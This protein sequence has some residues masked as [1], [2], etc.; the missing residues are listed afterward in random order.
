VVRLEMRKEEGGV[1][2]GSA[3]GVVRGYGGMVAGC[4]VLGHY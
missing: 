1:M 3:D 4:V 2:S